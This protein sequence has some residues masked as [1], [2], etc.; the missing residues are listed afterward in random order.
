MM[1]HCQCG[2]VSSHDNYSW[3]GWRMT[4]ASAAAT[5]HRPTTP[6]LSV[7]LTAHPATACLAC[8]CPQAHHATAGGHPHCAPCYCLPGLLLPTGPPRHGCRPSSVRAAQSRP[9]PL[10]STCGSYCH[11]LSHPRWPQRPHPSTWLM[12]RCCNNDGRQPQARSGQC[13][14]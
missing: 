1:T 7:I 10:P 4:L 13:F 5:A 8:Y 3:S 14:F 6:R 11:A 9:P 2:V 12:W